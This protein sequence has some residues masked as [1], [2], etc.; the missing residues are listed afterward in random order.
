MTTAFAKLTL[1]GAVSCSVTLVW[2]NH[3]NIRGLPGFFTSV[4]PAPETALD[5]WLGLMAA[6]APLQLYLV[7]LYG[8]LGRGSWRASSHFWDPML[9]AWPVAT[10][11]TFARMWQE[12]TETQANGPLFESLLTWIPL[13]AV[14]ASTVGFLRWR[15]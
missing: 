9:W 1:F 2:A 15:P 4:S 5:V 13:F 12:M 10:A 14:T 3:T 11:G 7:M 8:V 6:W